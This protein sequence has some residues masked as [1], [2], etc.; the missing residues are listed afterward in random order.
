MA[1][2]LTIDCGDC[3][4]RHSD[5]CGDCV[6]S[7]LLNR[8]PEDAVIIDAAEERGLRLLSQ[9]GLVPELRFEAKIS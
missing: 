9:A 2:C 1:A 8:E 6:V 3:Q 5:A 7:F 4:L